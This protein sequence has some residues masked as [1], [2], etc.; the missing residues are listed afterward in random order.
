[1]LVRSGRAQGI[2]RRSVH[3]FTAA[4]ESAAAG[5]SAPHA[6]PPTPPEERVYFVP[7][8]FRLALALALLA[9]GPPRVG[10]QP[11]AE[12]HRLEPAPSSARGEARPPALSRQSPAVES[13]TEPPLAWLGPHHVSAAVLAHRGAFSSCRTLAGTADEAHREGAIRL[14]WSVYASG[15]VRSVAIDR[16]SF[17]TPRVNAC[18]L[19]VAQKVRFPASRSAAQ[20]SWTV[21]FQGA[22]AE[23]LARTLD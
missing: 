22:S 1:M 17:Q 5:Q 12:A 14:G 21:R 3:Q 8:V 19:S 6:A 15:G 23:R 9:C 16:S 7:A 2:A 11:S 10:Q 13:A 4:A 18:M 20:V